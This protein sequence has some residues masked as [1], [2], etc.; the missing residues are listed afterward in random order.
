MYSKVE[1]IAP[2]SQLKENPSPATGIGGSGGI[3]SECASEIA[4]GELAH[5][6]ERQPRTVGRALHSR[7]QGAKHPNH[8]QKKIPVL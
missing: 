3:R 2:E 8:S 4:N 6:R 5:K 7:A 1:V